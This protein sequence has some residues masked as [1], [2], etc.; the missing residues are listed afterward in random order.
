MKPYQFNTWTW[1]VLVRAKTLCH[2]FAKTKGVFMETAFYYKGL[3]YLQFGKIEHPRNCLP[4]LDPCF[5]VRMIRAAPQ[6][7]Q[8]RLGMPRFVLV[9]FTFS[10][11]I[12][13][14]H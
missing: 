9:P 1:L 14:F 3:V 5:A 2:V 10:L 4:T 13:A 8:M 7:G 11:F 12:F 6:R